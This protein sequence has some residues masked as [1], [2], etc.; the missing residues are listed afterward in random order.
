M[1]ILLIFKLFH[2][3]SLI[4]S[5]HLF[6]DSYYE[7]KNDKDLIFNAVHFPNFETSASL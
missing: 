2:C 6:F 5:E 7:R 3:I 4:D 1:E